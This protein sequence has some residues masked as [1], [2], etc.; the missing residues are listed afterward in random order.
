MQI[1]QLLGSMHLL[2]GST[3]NIFDL[4]EWVNGALVDHG[5]TTEVNVSA[6]Q[7]SYDWENKH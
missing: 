2:K 6:R 3:H 1:R 5:P 7:R 4:S